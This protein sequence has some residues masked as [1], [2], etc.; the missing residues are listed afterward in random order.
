MNG[1]HKSVD[2]TAT[3]AT[4]YGGYDADEQLQLAGGHKE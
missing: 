2:V 3:K 1:L 4:F